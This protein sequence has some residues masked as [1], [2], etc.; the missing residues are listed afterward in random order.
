MTHGRPDWVRTTTLQDIRDVFGNI[1][2]VSM[3]ELAARLGSKQVF[4]RRGELVFVDDF[5]DSAFKWK[6]TLYSGA[7]AIR[8]TDYVL[9]GNFSA[10]L[11]TGTS[12]SGYARLS[13]FIHYPTLTRF[14]IE[15]A[16]SFGDIRHVSQTIALFDGTKMHVGGIQYSPEYNKLFWGFDVDGVSSWT[17]FQDNVDAREDYN[18]FSIMKLV[19]DFTTDKYL[20]A[21]FNNTEYDM[22]DY[23]IYKPANPLAPAIYIELNVQNVGASGNHITYLNHFILTQNEPE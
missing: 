9:T 4:E 18:A 3:G 12:T 17:E 22:S 23:S 2:Q 7:S 10:K 19:V 13:R 21:V 6:K 1:P 11:E 14:G 15:I 16:F 5:E 8:S 20:R